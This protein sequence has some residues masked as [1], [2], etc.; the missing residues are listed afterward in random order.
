MCQ[1]EARQTEDDCESTIV[2]VID[3]LQRSFESLRRT[4]GAQQR[5]AA[6]SGQRCLKALLARLRKVKRRKAELQR[7]AT[8]DD[9]AAFLKVAGC[10]CSRTKSFEL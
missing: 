2:G 3:S 10:T 5:E 7:L 4:I 9:D 6:A 1:T 8:M